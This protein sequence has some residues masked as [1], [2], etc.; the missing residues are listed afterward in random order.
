M[1]IEATPELIYDLREALEKNGYKNH[2]MRVDGNQLTITV[3]PNREAVHDHG[4]KVVKADF[5]KNTG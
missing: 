5:E 1:N 2:N 3:Q 4:S